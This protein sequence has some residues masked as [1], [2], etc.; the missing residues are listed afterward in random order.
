MPDNRLLP[1]PCFGLARGGYCGKFITPVALNPRIH[2][3]L[4]SL[5]EKDDWQSIGYRPY[6]APAGRE[7]SGPAGL[8]RSIQSM[9]LLIGYFEQPA[10]LTGTGTFLRLS[11][12][13]SMSLNRVLRIPI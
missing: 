7:T 13:L 5:P 10:R 9:F 4:F 3:P 8:S 1:L 12:A 11:N 6:R 2:C